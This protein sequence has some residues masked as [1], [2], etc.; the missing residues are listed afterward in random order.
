MTTEDTGTKSPS[1]EDLSEIDEVKGDQTGSDS[2]PSDSETN[3]SLSH[4]GDTEQIP[5]ASAPG[6]AGASPNSGRVKTKVIISK[7]IFP[8]PQN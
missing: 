4:L 6:R 5:G 7:L 1:E 8:H 3:S 2:E